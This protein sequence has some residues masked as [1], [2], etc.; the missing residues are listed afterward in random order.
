MIIVGNSF[1][2]MRDR[3]VADIWYIKDYTH[4]IELSRSTTVCCVNR[5]IDR[6]FK[7]DYSYIS[8]VAAV[9]EERLL[10]CPSHMTDV[11]SD[12]AVITFSSSGLDKLPQSTWEKP[13]EPQYE[14]CLDL[15]IVLKEKDR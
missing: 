12:T 5:S 8:Q 11:F 9:C 2:G 13:P 1:C 4:L 6:E 14:H 3:F 15:E 7:Q 10:P